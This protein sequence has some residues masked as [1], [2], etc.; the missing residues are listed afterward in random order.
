LG[1]SHA[2]Q[3][4]SMK[5]SP[6]HLQS[7]LRQ[8]QIHLIV[9]AL[10]LNEFLSTFYR[11]LRSL[12]AL[13]HWRDIPNDPIVHFCMAKEAHEKINE[14]R[15]NRKRLQPV[16]TDYKTSTFLALNLLFHA[17]SAKS[18]SKENQSDE[19]LMRPARQ[20]VTLNKQNDL[21]LK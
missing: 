12:K 8:I 16:K 3:Q 2:V 6:F 13:H 20:F 15:L 11:N 14:T 1:S 21:N 19:T 18:V 17:T 10:C 7:S 4:K 9:E 5:S